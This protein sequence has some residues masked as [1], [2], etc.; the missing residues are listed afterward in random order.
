MISRMARRP[1]S[2]TEV[3]TARREYSAAGLPHA[4]SSFR[5]VHGHSVLTRFLEAS[6]S[7]VEPQERTMNIHRNLTLSCALALL[8]APLYSTT[9]SA[10]PDRAA[11]TQVTLSPIVRRPPVFSF[12]YYL[13]GDFAF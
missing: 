13:P 4:R 7:G 1:L 6:C 5:N 8:L 12:N 11:T 9:T 10:A 2:H 3:P